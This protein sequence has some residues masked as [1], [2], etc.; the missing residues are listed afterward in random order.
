MSRAAVFMD[1]DG[2]II[3]DTGFIRRVEDVKL[4]P[5]A[6]EAISRLNAAGWLVIVVTNQSGV[7]RGLL[8][9]K[10]V[11]ATNRRMQELLQLEGAH[12][13]AIYYCP[14]LPEGKVSEYAIVCDCRKPRPGM[15]LKAV[16]EHD[17]DLSSSVMIGDAPRDVEAGLDA[18][19]RAI[20]LTES[21]TRADQAPDACGTAPDLLSAVDE[22]LEHPLTAAAG[23]K[24][25]QGPTPESKSTAGEKKKGRKR[26]SPAAGRTK[27]TSAKRTAVRSEKEKPVSDEEKPIPVHR[28]PKEFTPEQELTEEEET[29][30]ELEEVVSVPPEKGGTA[31]APSVKRCG[32]C[33]TVIPA[34]HIEAGE[35]YDKD[36]IRLC[37]ECVAALR[38]QRVQTRETTNEDVVREL[39]N[40]TRTL[41]YERFSYWHVFGAIAQAGAIG[42]V[43]ISLYRYAAP[44]GLLL[45]IF[46]QLLALTFFILGRQ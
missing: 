17:I 38:A 14:H 37:R 40:I 8:T 22:I 3:D 24:P 16:E 41:T 7:A 15:L 1:R 46:L 2:T 23:E 36:G 13:D 10:D 44:E 6:A 11:A 45:A 26:R 28:A 30:V 29:P 39:K 18:G 4:L 12:V 32:R 21:P 27:K 19:T 35:A 20:F 34:S 9:E 33:G 31:A 43:I 42:C 5:N 25:S